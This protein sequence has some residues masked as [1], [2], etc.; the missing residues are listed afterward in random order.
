MSIKDRSW[1]YDELHYQRN[2]GPARHKFGDIMGGAIAFLD[3][4]ILGGK[5]PITFND[6]VADHAL[7][8]PKNKC[9]E[10]SYPKPDGVF[11]LSL[12]HIRPCRRIERLKP[13]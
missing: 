9:K 4:N 2:F 6:K 8:R 12:I 11:N 13:R 10:I 7:I 1:I 5:L 3:M